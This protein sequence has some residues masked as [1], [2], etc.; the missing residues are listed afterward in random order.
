MNIKKL[1]LYFAISIGYLFIYATANAVTT[2]GISS[3]EM[4]A[5]LQEAR[6]P[7]NPYENC[8][9]DWALDEINKLNIELEGSPFGV[10]IQGT[11]VVFEG[12]YPLLGT[13]SLMSCS[14]MREYQ[15][16]LQ[17]LPLYAGYVG[18]VGGVLVGYAGGVLVLPPPPPP[19]PFVEPI[20]IGPTTFGG[21]GPVSLQLTFN[22]LSSS[23]SVDRDIK[24]ISVNVD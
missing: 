8:L 14:Q 16:Y 23:F 22:D 19:V 9:A 1:L 24:E 3:A 4:I 21:D 12:G 5:K 18:Y 15:F 10:E 20:Y 13:Q 17:N 6:Q 2:I 11:S 7:G